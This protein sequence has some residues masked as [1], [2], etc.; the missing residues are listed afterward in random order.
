[1]T[2]RIALTGLEATG[3]HGVLEHER[4]DGQIFVVDVALE[5]DTRATARSDDVADTVNYA[6]VADRVVAHI[7]GEPVNLIETLAERIATDILG[8]YLV[9]A[10][11]VTVHKPHA[12]IDP[13]F[14]DVSVSIR[15][16]RS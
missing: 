9:N 4:R 14:T 13:T 6:E 2:D 5:V 16:E 7:S 1:V 15:R 3:H 12:P 10:V 8:L 11:E